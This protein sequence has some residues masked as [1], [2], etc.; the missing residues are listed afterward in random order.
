MARS[1]EQL[2]DLIVAKIK[3]E[4]KD[5]ERGEDWKEGVTDEIFVK[6][7]DTRNWECKYKDSNIINNRTFVVRQFF[8]DSDEGALSMIFFTFVV[9]CDE[10]D[11]FLDIDFYRQ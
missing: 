5:P 11:D 2:K 8:F 6:L 7:C 1:A 4:W 9:T 3:E 10:D